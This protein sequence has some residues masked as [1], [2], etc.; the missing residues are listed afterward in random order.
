MTPV[1]Y[2]FYQFGLRQWCFQKA[3][4]A[5]YVNVM[6]SASSCAKTR[7]YM[8]NEMM[9]LKLGG[10]KV[11]SNAVT[12]LGAGGKLGIRHIDEVPRIKRMYGVRWVSWEHKGIKQVCFAPWTHR[13]SM[14]WFCNLTTDSRFLFHV[15]LGHLFCGM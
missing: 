10:N 6:I 12:V 9:Q 1:L 14:L 3:K 13:L 8:H 5:R 2:C 11:L 15:F 7:K 4:L